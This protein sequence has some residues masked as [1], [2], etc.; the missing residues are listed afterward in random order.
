MSTKTADRPKVLILYASYGDGH[1]QA[2]KALKESFERAGVHEVVMIDLFA[3]AYPFINALTKF[4]Y[5]K[6]YTVFPRLYG[7]AYYSTRYM[8]NDTLVS[9]WFHSFGLRKLK[10]IIRKVQP[11]LVINTF[12]MLVMPEFRKKTGVVLPTYHVLTDFALHH[13]WLHPNVDKYYV[14]TE[15]L[16]DQVAQTGIPEDRIRVSGIPLKAA[17]GQPPTVSAVLQKYRLRTDRPTVLLMAG[18]YGVL[19][20]LKAVCRSLSGLDV[21]VLVVCGRNQMLF[22]DMNR[23]FGD[24]PHFRI[25]GF[26]QEIHELMAVSSLIVTKPGGI[27]LSEALTFHLPIVLFRPVPGQERDNA[28]YLQHKGAAV[29]ANHPQQL[30]EQIQTLLANPER[31]Q[32]MREASRALQKG[33]SSET[34]VADILDDVASFS[35]EIPVTS[36]KRSFLRD[37]IS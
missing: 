30:N 2:S 28:I 11:D 29:I 12:P 25:F 22:E 24:L 32:Q 20:G 16:R 19:Q 4:I 35:Q 17:F 21:Q 3:E 36:S 37:F 14:A 33:N 10:E 8:R 1:F 9:S 7:W 34:I 31:L 27:T 6:S 18:S 23:S 5:I 26:V 13:R 15:D